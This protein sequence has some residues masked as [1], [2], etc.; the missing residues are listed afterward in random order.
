MDSTLQ[1]RLLQ[2]KNMP[3]LPAVTIKVLELCQ[4]PEPDV[5][6]VVK[7]ITTDAA[8]A[9]KVLRMANSPMLG[10]RREV[11][12]VSHAV[13]MLGL[14]SLRAMALSFSLARTL[15]AGQAP[16]FRLY[17]KRSALC[18][19]TARHLAATVGFRD[20]E[21]AFL[22]GL[23]QDIGMLA[24]SVVDPGYGALIEQHGDNHGE[25]IAREKELFG[26]DHA[27]VGGWLAKRWQLPG[28][29]AAILEQ[30]HGVGLV[31]PAAEPTS[32]TLSRVVAVANHLAD[33]W[34]HPDRVTTTRHARAFAQKVLDL[35][36]AQFD[37]VLAKVHDTMGELFALL[38]APMDSREAIDAILEEARESLL[39]SAVTE[40]IRTTESIAALEERA[41]KAEEKAL[42]DPL[43]GLANRA[44]FEAFIEK[45]LS[46]SRYTEQPLSLIVIDVDH[47]KKV[48]DTHGHL[49]GDAVLKAIGSLF[50]RAFRPRDLPARCGGEEFMIV[51]PDTP[52]AGSVVVAERIRER[53]AATPVPVDGGAVL[54][55][56]ASLGCATAVPPT[57]SAS[58]AGLIRLADE[59][60]Y[61]AKQSGRNQVRTMDEVKHPAEKG[62]AA[63]ARQA[64]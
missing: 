34:L 32:V 24:L 59:A 28:Q 62:Q 33:V 31:D 61:M 9:S 37:G 19:L 7:T 1:G 11:T 44:R 39:L 51:L 15:K 17:W 5:K 36:D 26:A 63:A 29:L 58:V 42:T 22:T 57:Q 14:N 55:V 25:V 13:A 45:E 8:L 10:V 20:L 46:K 54:H 53:I 30:S 56:T 38:D 60:M 3:A 43:T 4:R 35:T 64:L 21:E 48:N 52:L 12:T 47:F 27:E 6:E 16:W 49:A 41:T 2:A 23:M 40:Q 50:A 18:G